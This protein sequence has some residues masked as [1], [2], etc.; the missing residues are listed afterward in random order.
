[1]VVGGYEG[2]GRGVLEQGKM[3]FI[4]I[5]FSGAVPKTILARTANTNYKPQPT[6][7][8]TSTRRK[9]GRVEEENVVLP[10]VIRIKY[11]ASKEI[12]NSVLVY[13]LPK[14]IAAET[15]A[16]ARNANVVGRVKKSPN[17][18][19]DSS[20]RHKTSSLR[21]LAAVATS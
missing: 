10:R 1:M 11:E 6:L 15:A 3:G 12:R 2:G 13:F 8:I 14:K 16:P 19:S 7:D 5:A 18:D 21:P 20:P 4:S 9:V 17:E